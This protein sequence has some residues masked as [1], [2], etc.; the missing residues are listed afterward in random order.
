MKT[1]EMDFDP[2]ISAKEKDR[3][4]YNEV[5]EQF[6]GILHVESEDVAGNDEINDQSEDIKNPI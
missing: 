6:L 4:N 2:G 1:I 3:E 5:I